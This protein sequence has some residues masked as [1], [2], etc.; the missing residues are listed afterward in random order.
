MQC[1]L[2]ALKRCASRQELREALDSLPNELETTYEKILGEIDER[3]SEGKLARRALGWLVVAMEPLHLAQIV[4]GL[5]MD[6]Q[7][8][9]I[10]RETLGAA[11]LHALS[12]LV[13]YYEETD[14][15]ALS[16]F[17]VQVRFVIFL[18]PQYLH[19]LFH[20]NILLAVPHRRRT[21]SSPVR[22]MRRLYR[23]ACAASL[24]S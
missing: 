19:S 12:S 23:Y 17:S 8:R 15:I 4:D 9:K 3:R 22:P 21:R 13:S 14:V 10:E 16:H 24:S 5:S 6:P 20:R 7:Q 18:H 1:Q 11:L 2:D